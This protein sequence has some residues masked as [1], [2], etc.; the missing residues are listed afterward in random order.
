MT[1]TKLSMQQA[2]VEQNHKNENVCNIGQGE[3]RLKKLRGLH[4]VGVKL[5]TA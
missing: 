2:Q 4:L 3:D 1:V 5:T